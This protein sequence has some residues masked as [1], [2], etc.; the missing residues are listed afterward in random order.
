MSQS[1]RLRDR[2]VI[3][4]IS[5]ISLPP[6]EFRQQNRYLKLNGLYVETVW[7][8]SRCMSVFAVLLLCVVAGG[9]L[10]WGSWEIVFGAGSFFVTLPMLVLTALSY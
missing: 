7:S 3:D 8:V 10:I 5:D 1:R 6:H 9:K 4:N 2:I